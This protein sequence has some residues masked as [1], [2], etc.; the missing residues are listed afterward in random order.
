MEG[1]FWACGEFS[2]T[3]GSFGTDVAHFASLSAHGPFAVD[4]DWGDGGPHTTFN[5]GT[6]GA[7]TGQNHTYAEEGPYTVNVKVTDTQTGHSDTQSFAVSVS[8]PAVT[9]TGGFTFNAVEGVPSATQTVATFTDPGGPEALADYSVSIDWGDG[10]PIDT[11]SGA[12]SG[13]DGS[14]VYTVTGSHTFASGLGLPSDFGNTLCD[15][16]PPSYHKTI[17]VTINH[18]VAPPALTSSDALITLP[19][20]SAHLAGDGSLIIVGTTGDDKIL[21]NPSPGNKANTVTVLLG[22]S[23]L[24]TF[25]L[26]SGGRVVVAALDGNDNIQIAGGVKLN[27]VLYGGPGNDRI[28]GGNGQNIEVGCEGNDQLLGGNGHDLLVGGAGSDNLNGTAGGDTLIAG[29]LLDASLMEDDKY[30]DLV[31]VLNSTA[32]N[33]VQ[34]VG[35]SAGDDGAVDVLQGAGG[36]DTLYYRFSGGGVLDVV[37]GKADHRFNT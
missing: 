17:N 1:D 37:H 2:T 30:L 9:P 16:N 8:D 3:G 13:P 35:L 11:T 21:V 36:S 32:A 15:A 14:G 28:N 27:T 6:L 19:P 7:V 10:T 33:P 29:L 20:A 23:S 18:D 5:Q 31:A 12:I 22:S 26:G 24:G 34:A 4:V 25:T